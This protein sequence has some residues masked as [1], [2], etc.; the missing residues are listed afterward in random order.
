MLPCVKE[1]SYCDPAQLFAGFA[2]EPGA[3]FLDSAKTDDDL[4][5]YSFIGVDPFLTLA[6]DVSARFA[7]AVGGTTAE[8]E[9]FGADV[10]ASVKALA[11]GADGMDLTFDRGDS[12]VEV[13]ITCGAGSRVVA[14]ALL[15][16]K[17]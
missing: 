12:G 2:T 3:V 13:A 9:A 8:A 10:A 4:G 11:R 14:H 6:A 1:I 5:R 7:E 16:R 15:A 17:A